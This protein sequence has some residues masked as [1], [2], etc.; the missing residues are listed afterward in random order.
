LKNFEILDAADS[1]WLVAHAPHGEIVGS[2][3][4]LVD[5]KIAVLEFEQDVQD[6][7]KYW[8][9]GDYVCEAGFGNQVG[10]LPDFKI[11]GF[12][13]LRMTQQQF[14]EICETYYEEHS[15]YPNP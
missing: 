7:V 3:D 15:H 8:V 4:S 5:A 1:S 11:D 13:C 9:V 12:S 6:E 2:Y 14:D 10:E